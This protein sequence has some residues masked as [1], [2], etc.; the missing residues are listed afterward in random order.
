MIHCWS[1][2]PAHVE[3]QHL[4]YANQLTTT[5]ITGKNWFEDHP[6][7]ASGLL[8]SPLGGPVGVHPNWIFHVLVAEEIPLLPHLCLAYFVTTA[9]AISTECRH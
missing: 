3:H 9:M 4:L 6:V 8:I 2:S 7:L 5:S 1:Q